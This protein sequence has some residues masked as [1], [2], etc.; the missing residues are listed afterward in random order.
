[1]EVR[2]Q[3]FHARA[4]A[5]EFEALKRIQHTAQTRYLPNGIYGITSEQFGQTHVESAEIFLRA[6]IRILQYRDKSLSGETKPAEELIDSALEVKALCRK[7]GATFIVDD[8]VDVAAAVGADGVHLGQSDMPIGYARKQFNGIIGITAENAAQARS[9][10]R[11][12]A[13]YIGASAV[14]RSSTKPDVAAMGPEGLRKIINS[15]SLPVYGIG[16][17]TQQ[18]LQMVKKAGAAGAAVISAVLAA[19]HPVDQAKRL[20][21][22]WSA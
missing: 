14:F 12:G 15:V 16:G 17:I 6:G 1:M 22:L 20:V 5:G 2:R 19:E 8:R 9:A 3:R 13:D 11:R 7:Y 10:E 18:N 4:N 21:A